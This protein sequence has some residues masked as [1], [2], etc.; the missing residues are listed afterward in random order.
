MLK[1][2]LFFCNKKIKNRNC[3]EEIEAPEGCHKILI[4]ED[5]VATGIFLFL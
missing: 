4:V 5:V 3:K 2:P 1:K